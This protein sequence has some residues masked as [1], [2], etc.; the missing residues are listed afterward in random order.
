MVKTVILLRHGKVDIE[1]KERIDSLAMQEWVKEY[2]ESP[3][4]VDSLPSQKSIEY[5]HS[6]DYVFSSQLRRTH[7][8]AKVLGVQVNEQNSLFNEADIPIAKIPFFKFCPK[9]WLIILRLLLLFK[10]GRTNSSFKASK[11]RAQ[12]AT[13]HLLL[14]SRAYE[15]IAL[16]GHGGL[17]W[18][19]SEELKKRG[20]KPLFPP[21]NKN[22]GLRV[23]TI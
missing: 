18:L 11:K 19:I 8:S 15:K 1:T 10:V 14:E 16:I 23:Y 2:D 4:A 20:W 7:D 9:T 5:L 6:A 3:L 13:E 17:N 22:W 12:K 21:S